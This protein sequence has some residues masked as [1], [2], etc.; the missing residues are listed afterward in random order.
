MSLHR[1]ALFILR[2]RGLIPTELRTWWLLGL[3]AAYIFGVLVALA[4]DGTLAWPLLLV[5]V[6]VM[7]FDWSGYWTL[8]HRVTWARAGCLGG[9][10]LVCVLLTGLVAPACVLVDVLRDTW[11]ARQREMASRPT[12][13]RAL[14][15]ELGL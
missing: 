5:N 10:W 2:L 13:I 6:G 12:H 15:R 4:S 7:A 9:A 1:R 3:A 11:R 8:G 14:E